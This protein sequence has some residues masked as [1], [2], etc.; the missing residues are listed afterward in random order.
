[1]L[2]CCILST[3]LMTFT[4]CG[5]GVDRPQ[6]YPVSGTV[7]YNGKPVEKASVSFWVDG[8]SRAATG[9]T[10]A[11]G[12]FQL[13]MFEA[14]DGALPGEHTITVSKVEPGAAAAG[15]PTPEQMLADPN[16]LAQMG[17]ATTDKGGKNSGPK[18]LIPAKYGDRMNTTL[19]ETVTA[20]G[21]NQFVLQLTD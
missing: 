11:E 10:D 2:F 3:V 18:K 20:D 13:S 21:D 16:A 17:A 9:V 5:G 7:M 4:G 1:M 8:A 15:G 12:K 14:N 6:T 19:K